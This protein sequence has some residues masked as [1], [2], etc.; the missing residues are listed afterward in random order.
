M[1]KNYTTPEFETIDLDTLDV[2]ANSTLNLLDA[3][4]EH[5]GGSDPSANDT[6][7]F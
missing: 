2:I 6:I 3:I 1:R 4:K 7:N 5:M